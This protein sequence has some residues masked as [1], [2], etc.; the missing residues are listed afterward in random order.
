MME[1]VKKFFTGLASITAFLYATGYIAEYAH[2]RML[3]IPM[4]Q[5]LN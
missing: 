1:K 5:P 2:A 3:G 4:G